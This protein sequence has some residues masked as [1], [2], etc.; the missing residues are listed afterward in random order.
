MQTCGN[1]LPHITDKSKAL[2]SLKIP[3]VLG[4]LIRVLSLSGVMVK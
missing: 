3:F 4:D 1:K 2:V